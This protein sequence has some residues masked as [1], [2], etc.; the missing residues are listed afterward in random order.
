MKK[1]IG[2]VTIAGLLV[3]CSASKNSLQTNKIETAG[4]M[5]QSAKQLMVL[6][7]QLP[8]GV[9]PRSL[10]S[11]GTLVTCPPSNWVS[12]FYIGTLVYLY[13]SVGDAQLLQ[14]A[15]ARAK[16]LEN[17]QFNT[18]THDLGFMMFCSY[19]NLNR[20]QPSAAYQQILLN[21]AKSLAT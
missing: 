4:I 6:K 5:S 8:P 10:D 9:L 16:L 13:E 21:G 17:E 19:G 15:T 1:I 3:A 7:R 18:N 11:A 20:I 12:G 14:E 2:V